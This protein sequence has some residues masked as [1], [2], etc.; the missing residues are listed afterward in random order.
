M[1]WFRLDLRL[2]D[3]PALYEAA[4]R[5]GP[6][7]PVYVWSP[8]E[9]SP[10]APGGASR[11][12]LHHSL[13]A[14]DG[15]LRQLGSRLIVRRGPTAEALLRVAWE[16]GAEAVYANRRLEPAQRRI[17]E[18]VRRAVVEAGLE[19]R[20][21]PDGTL[22]DPEKIRTR[23]GQ[24]FQVFTPFWRACLS[25]PDPAPPLPTPA[26]LVSP[27]RWPSSLAVGEL[28][29]LPKPDWAGG[30][31][32][33]WQVGESHAWGRWR[34]FLVEGMDAYGAR[35]D[36]PAVAGTSRLSPHLHFGEISVRE[37]WHQ[38]AAHARGP[39]MG[40]DAWRTGAFLRELLWREFAHYLLFHY[41]HTAEEP[42]RA[43]WKRFP[44]RED[45]K[46][47]QAWRRGRT[48]YPIVDAGM[49]QLWTT[50]WMHNRVRMIVASFLVKDLRIHWLEG[51]RWFWDTLVDAD[52]ANNTLGWQWSAGCGADA[53]PYFRIFHP[54]RQGEKFDPSGDYVRRWCPELSRL[55]NE[56][57][58]RPFEAPPLVLQAAGVRLGMDYPE[59]VV[60]H[61][62]ARQSALA[63]WEQMVQGR[64]QTRGPG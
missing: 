58:H 15:S 38:V 12:W 42:L 55:P 14:L 21:F 7:V 30:L 45:R 31:R 11:W 53:A 1:V 27:V 36:L 3:Q 25:G 60:S 18:S 63:A 64:Q 13:E 62:A 50:G 8:E 16:S 48:G 4:R 2:R 37:L 35:R 43:D 29:L 40:N 24:P 51:A 59:P 41:P 33:N 46:A 34:A 10:W 39:G 52:L 5:G 54:V 32:A 28:G 44:W 56:W 57:I 23:S 61:A 22:F 6:V 49:R 19:Y 9:E 47:L 20:E 26:A 17:G